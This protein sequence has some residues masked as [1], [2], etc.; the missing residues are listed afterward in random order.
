MSDPADEA[1]AAELK[2]NW[3]HSEKNGPQWDKSWIIISQHCP[4]LHGK[5][6][7]SGGG[8]S[9]ETAG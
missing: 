1:T 8:L 2:S 9:K 5:A 4:G 6:R 7:G 3:T